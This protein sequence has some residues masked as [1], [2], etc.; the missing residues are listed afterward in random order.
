MTDDHDVHNISGNFQERLHHKFATNHLQTSE[1]VVFESSVY[2][3]PHS[4]LLI[5]WGAVLKTS[6][7]LNTMHKV[8]TQR[9]GELFVRNMLLMWL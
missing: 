6:F 9:F 5:F 1:K 2:G 4:N 3:P 7:F 8:K